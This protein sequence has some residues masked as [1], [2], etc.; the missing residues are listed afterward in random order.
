MSI[1]NITK[2]LT[3]P[4]ELQIADGAIDQYPRA[5]VYDQDSV[6]LT[7]IDLVHDYQGNY[8][9][10]P[11][12]MPDKLYIKVVF[13]VYS[14]ALFAVENIKYERALEIFYSSDWV[15]LTM[16]QRISNLLRLI[17]INTNGEHQD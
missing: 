1:Q 15:T 2:G 9:G 6:L 10:T 17:F 11:Y 3:V 13:I 8:S 16:G 7:T 4:I 12:V 14:D 5:L